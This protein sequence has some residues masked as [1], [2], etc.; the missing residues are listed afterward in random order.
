M[1]RKEDEKE[2][3]IEAKSFIKRMHEDKRAREKQKNKNELL[4][5]R[6]REAE[7]NKFLEKAEIDKKNRLD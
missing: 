6:L 1:E 5:L 3:D 4:K 2:K 7:N